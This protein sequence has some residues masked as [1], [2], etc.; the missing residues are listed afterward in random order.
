MFE[1]AFAAA[2][3]G[4]TEWRQQ[5]TGTRLAVALVLNQ[6]AWLEEMG[7]TIA[8]AITR[9]GEERLKMIPSDSRAVQAEI[10]RSISSGAI[11]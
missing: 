3:A 9:V 1:A 11:R 10:A 6:H 5:T 4:E 2:T 8:E 7:Y